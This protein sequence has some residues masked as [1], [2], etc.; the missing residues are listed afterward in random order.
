MIKL[1]PETIDQGLEVRLLL[2]EVRGPQ[3]VGY[4]LAD[5]TK[6][7]QWMHVI[8]RNRIADPKPFGARTGTLTSVATAH[9]QFAGFENYPRIS[10]AILTNL[11]TLLRIA[12]S[13]N[14]RRSSVFET[15]INLAI[16]T[17]NATNLVDPSPGRL[18]AWRTAGA[19]SPGKEFTFYQRLSFNDYYYLPVP[20]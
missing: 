6:A 19:T 2:A 16:A 4:N 14:D 1:P 15:H 10:Q 7:M 12:N 20:V 18:A 9:N 13:A 17:A 8:L 5:A 11:T 3:Q